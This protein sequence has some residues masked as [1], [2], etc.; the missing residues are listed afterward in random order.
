MAGE[1]K[2]PQKNIPR[3]LLIGVF[4]CV[5]VYVLVNQAYLYALPVE[6]VA[7]SSLVASD[8]IGVAIGNTGEAIIAA[9]I[10]ICTLGAINGNVMAP[11]R[12][13][14]AM[15]KDKIFLPWAGKEHKRFQ[16]PGNAMWLHGIWTC[17]FIITGSFDMLADMFVFVTWVA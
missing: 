5:V 13:T 1:V 12:I 16:T 17:L 4:V 2:N 10:V 9:L 7:A 15:G 3:S 6:V 11:T 8:A 14:Y